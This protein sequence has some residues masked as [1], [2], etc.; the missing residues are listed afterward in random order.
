MSGKIGGKRVFGLGILLPAIFTILTPL[1]ATYGGLNWLMYV[2]IMEGMGEGVTYPALMQFWSKWAPKME[3]SQL[4]ALS[5][6]GAYFGTVVAM[7]FSGFLNQYFGWRWIFYVY[8]G[9]G[10]L[11]FVIWHFTAAES[12]EGHPFIFIEETLYIER[13]RTAEGNFINFKDIPWKKI[14]SSLPFYA[15]VCAHFSD[16]WAYYTL[17]TDLPRYMNEIL[18]LNYVESGILSSIPYLVLIITST[19]MGFVA[20]LLRRKKYLSTKAV[21]KL[22]NTISFLGQS[23]FLILAGYTKNTMVVVLYISLSVGFCGFK[24]GGHISNYLDISSRY[25]SVLMG[26][27][28]TIS[29]IPG[30]ISLTIVGI[31]TSDQTLEEWRIVFYI[32]CAVQAVGG[33]FFLIF[34]SGET[35]SWNND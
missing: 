17:L 23:T 26:I 1:A 10:C 33:I 15:I 6:S 31:L 5:M 4:V 9:F 34:A 18:N 28:N 25:V 27:S 35:Q 19:S 24:F 16:N 14:S 3:R 29:T 22:F 13:T 21:R 7:P 20:D 12:P 30:I 11:W 32:S 2:R 8:G